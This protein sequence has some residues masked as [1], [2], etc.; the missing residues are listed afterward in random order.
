MR[1]RVPWGGVPKTTFS[2]SGQVTVVLL[3]GCGPENLGVGT[4]RPLSVT[5]ARSL[6]FCWLCRGPEDPFSMHW[7]RTREP[8]AET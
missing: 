4:R 6:S 8:W 1:T 5:L 3:A 7:V 2:D